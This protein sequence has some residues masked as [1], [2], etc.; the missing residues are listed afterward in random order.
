MYRFPRVLHAA[1]LG[2]LVV[3][4]SAMLPASAHAQRSASVQR[5]VSVDAPTFAITN[6]TVIDGT[7]SAPARG[8]TVVVQDGKITAIGPDVSV[9]AGAER[10]DGSGKTLLPGLVGLHNH[11]FYTTSQRRIQLDFTAPLLYLASGVTTI[12]TTGS[13]APYSELELKRAIENGERVGPR[14][15]VT[16]PYVTGGE[17]YTYMTRLGEPEDA[18]RV[19]RYWAE[20]GVDWFKA[21][22]LISREELAAVIDE[23]HRHGV[24]V[25]GHLCSVSFREAVKLGIDNLEHGFFTNTDYAEGKVPDGCPSDFREQLVA[26]DMESE[27]VQETFRT[28]INAG[29]GMTSTLAVYEM[30]VPNRPPLEDRVL[31]AMSPETQKEYLRTRSDIAEQNSAVW[32]EL[33]QRAL[34]YE[35]AFVEAGGLLASGVDP[36]GY[37]GALPGYGDQR[38]FELLHEAGFTTPEVVQIMSLNGARILGIDD[39]TGSVQ[40]GKTA[41]L[42]LVDGD[43]TARPASIRNVETVFRSGTGFDSR[44]LIEAVEGQVGVR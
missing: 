8:V 29:V 43:L 9:P 16:G 2:V 28:M 22:T 42:V 31:A 11:T 33:Y 23:A 34:A 20:E 7:G 38:N 32:P 3:F 4:V 39:E 21:Y 36:T 13:Y 44:L 14:M 30:Y 41:D 12:R 6:V 25:T 15:F 35:K 27:E 40:V 37:G 18:R 1:L 17:G 19:T 10:I 5:F 26:M 24:K